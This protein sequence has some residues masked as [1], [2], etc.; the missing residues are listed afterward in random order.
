[1]FRP[2]QQSQSYLLPPNLEDFVGEGHPAS[3]AWYNQAK[4]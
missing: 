2:Y 3:V 4:P 1:M